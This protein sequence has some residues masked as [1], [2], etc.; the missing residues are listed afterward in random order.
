MNNCSRKGVALLIIIV[1]LTVLS[2]VIYRMTLRLA[3]YRHRQQYL[4]DY[5]QARYACDSAMKYA[6]SETASI[7]PKLIERPNEPDFSDVFSMTNQEYIEWINAWREQMAEM[8]YTDVND[9]NM[10]V[11]SNETAGADKMAMALE[12]GLLE[13][14]NAMKEMAGEEMSDFNDPN[15][16][17]D[18]N[19]VDANEAVAGEEFIVRGPYGP[20]WPYVSEP[21]EFDMGSAKVRIEIID[22]NAKFPLVWVLSRDEEQKPAINTAVKL[23]FAWMTP[24]LDEEIDYYSGYAVNAEQVPDGNYI[25]NTEP[26]TIQEEYVKYEDMA[27]DFARIQAIKEYSQ[28]L[29]PIVIEETVNVSGSQQ[30]P[31]ANT[32]RGRAARRRSLRQ[33]YAK[34]RTTRQQKPMVTHTRDFARLLHSP[35]LDIDALTRPVYSSE[36][37]RRYESALKYL[38]LWGSD[39]INI[40]T[41]PRH[42]LEAAFLFGGDEV[43]VAEAI[44][45]KRRIKPFK[46]MTELKKEL[47]EFSNSVAKAEPFICFQ[48]DIYSIRITASSGTASCIAEAGVK[49]QGK[50]FYK[51]GVINSN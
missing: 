20:Q 31:A 29:Q 50:E 47:N 5:Q 9:A 42:V 32:A 51:I 1:L 24:R 35:M 40:N 39:K 16:F 22:E 3:T 33:R 19:S 38:G 14:F 12:S 10:P 4:I 44:I 21:V 28:K 49:K 30:Q 25:E 13:M 45:Q 15:L 8:D 37:P 17:F 7:R 34:T 18:F 41:A 2:A 23:F 6:L 27:D 43:D 26:Q 11:E 36:N 46:D 48:S